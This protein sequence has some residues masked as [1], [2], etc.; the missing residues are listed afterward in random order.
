MLLHEQFD[1]VWGDAYDGLFTAKSLVEDPRFMSLR[2]GALT[3]VAAV[4]VLSAG[5]SAQNNK[6]QLEARSKELQAIFAVVDDVASG[7][8]GPDDLGLTWVRADFLKAQE[9]KGYVPFTV[10]L[11]PAQVKSGRV[12]L[13]WRVVARDG[14]AAP[15]TPNDKKKKNE[16]IRYPYEDLTTATVSSAGTSQISRSF[17]V[18]AGTYDVYVLA[19][20]TPSTQKN[21]PAPKVSVLKHEVTV[22]DFW[23]SELST[24]SLIVVDRIDPIPAPLS[25]EQKADRPYAL[26]T[27]E[28]VPADTT[29]FPKTAELSTFMQIYNAGTDAASR[30]DVLVE[31]SFYKRSAGV[32]DAFFNKT[33][34]QNLNAQTIPPE[35]S[36]AAGHQLQTGQA[37][38]LSAF[39]E[40]D[41]RLEI[42]VTDKIANRTLTRDLHFSVRPS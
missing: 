19:K 25:R 37:I 16:K 12:D 7:R 15:S 33:L 32:P 3:L 28:I 17:T 40:G 10:S 24:S 2:R 31:C 6:K 8:Q 23:N 14:S 42:K 29:T 5:L 35:F 38:L 41:Y 30:P 34:P 21:A 20:E 22:P 9:G 4:L 27:F 36:F 1:L 11:D 26:G 13:Y 39:P 18:A